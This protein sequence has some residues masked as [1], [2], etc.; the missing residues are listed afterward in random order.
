MN[1]FSK[2]SFAVNFKLQVL[3]SLQK[4]KKK[5]KISG[6][7]SVRIY[8]IGIQFFL[9]IF[10]VCDFLFVS[11]QPCSLI[12]T[13]YNLKIFLLVKGLPFSEPHLKLF[14]FFFFSYKQVDQ[15]PILQGIVC[16]LCINQLTGFYV[17]NL[18]VAVFFDISCSIEAYCPY[19]T[20]L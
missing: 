14:F 11:T 10:L 3:L 5:K 2:L 6:L 16:V 4:N 18:I 19:A 12:T 15:N 1:N 13:L 17:F 20:S 9:S 7:M 8:V